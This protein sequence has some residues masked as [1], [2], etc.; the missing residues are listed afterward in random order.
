MLSAVK[1]T[2]SHEE[3]IKAVK[4]KK[5]SGT[6]FWKTCSLLPLLSI[7]PVSRNRGLI[8]RQDE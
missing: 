2:V 7:W 4:D 5:K 3:I 8:I 1:V 6:P